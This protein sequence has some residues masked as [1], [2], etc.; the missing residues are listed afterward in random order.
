MTRVIAIMLVSLLSSGCVEASI[1][2][3]VKSRYAPDPSRSDTRYADYVACA[4]RDN[5][6]W[7]I[8]DAC[9]VSKGHTVKK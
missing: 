1:L 9:M 3:T 8:L 7:D 4:L 5:G 6:S 2:V